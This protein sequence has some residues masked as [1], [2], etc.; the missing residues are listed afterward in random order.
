MFPR[1]L[2]RVE[3]RPNR[4][5]PPDLATWPYSIP[6]VAQLISEGG[7]DIPPGITF[8]VGENG[9][10]KSTLI[11]AI[12]DLYPRRGH[13]TRFAA[14]TGPEPSDEDSPLVYHLRPRLHRSASPAG[15]FLRAEAMHGFFSMLDS[16][17]QGRAWGGEKLQQRSHGESFLAV[18]RHRFDEQGV[19]FLDEPE[20]ALS[21]QSCLAL[22]ALLDKMRREGSQ[23]LVATHSPMLVTL[24]GAALIE[25]DDAGFRRVDRFEDLAMFQQWRSFLRD[26]NR[27]F[28]H[29]FDQAGASSDDDA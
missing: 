22:I 25:L 26:P 13:A 29:L 3:W 16:T 19:Y 18:L 14:V 12:A 7:M 11:E 4:Q 24:P 15:F 8:L 2:E 27:Y 10:G 6:A 1:H 17:D 20:A 21:F 5:Q 28:R 23:V 9:S